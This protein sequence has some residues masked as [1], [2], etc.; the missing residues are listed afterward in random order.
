MDTLKFLDGL[1]HELEED[2]RKMFLGYL[3][4]FA[5]TKGELTR[6]NVEPFVIELMDTTPVYE[7]P[8]RYNRTLTGCINEEV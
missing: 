3:Y 8:M 5:L 7:K 1:P 4:N 6:A 2:V